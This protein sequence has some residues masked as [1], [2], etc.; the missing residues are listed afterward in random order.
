MNPNDDSVLSTPHSALSS[1][2]PLYPGELA[3]LIG[4]PGAGK[5]LLSLDLATRITTHSHLPP[6]PFTPAPDDPDLPP[7]YALLPLRRKPTPRFP[8][9]LLRR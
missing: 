5:S 7:P 3:L 1:P 4:H 9:R 6:A 2:F 8:P